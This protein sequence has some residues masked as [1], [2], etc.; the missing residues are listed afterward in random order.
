MKIRLLAS[1]FLAALLLFWGCNA[2]EKTEQT[3][4]K[5]ND[6]VTLKPIESNTTIAIKTTKGGMFLADNPQKLLIIDIFATW[7]PPCRAEAEVLSDI[8]KKYPKQVAII[9]ITVEQKIDDAKLAAFAKNNNATY[10]L[11]NSDANEKIIDKVTKDIEI[12]S[13]FPIP[14]MV[15]YKDGKVFRHYE[16]ATEEEFILSDIKQALQ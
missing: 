3:A 2:K 1:V 11:V 16:G 9:G 14:L 10:T 6:I 7:C 15:I 13:R 12:G 5:K 4:A 8:Q